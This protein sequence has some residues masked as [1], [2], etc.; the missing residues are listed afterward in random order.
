MHLFALCASA[1]FLAPSFVAAQ[2]TPGQDVTV[3]YLF[4][5]QSGTQGTCEKQV[6]ATCDFLANNQL[7]TEVTATQFIINFKFGTSSQ[8]TPTSFH[9]Q[10]ERSVAVRSSANPL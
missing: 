7:H 10:S 1:L 8:L 5:T 2:L 4:P 3:N 9:G 6:P